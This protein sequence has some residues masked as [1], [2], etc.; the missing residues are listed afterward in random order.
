[1]DVDGTVLLTRREIG[2]RD[3]TIRFD[4]SDLK[5][6]LAL[7]F[8]GPES[9]GRATL[10]M[11]LTAEQLDIA[12]VPRFVE[13][14]MPLDIDTRFEAKR[15]H[16][17]DLGAGRILAR[18]RQNATVLSVD[19]LTVSDLG[20]ATLAAT[21]AI[22]PQGGT[23]EARLEAS[24]LDALAELMARVLPGGLTSWLAKRTPLYAPASLRIV[25]DSHGM[26]RSELR[27][28]Q[29]A[30]TLG[31]SRVFGDARFTEDWRLIAGGGLNL[32]LEA[33]QSTQLL[34]QV[35]IDV[36]QGVEINRPGRV[37]VALGGPTGA[38]NADL[39]VDAD[40]GVARLALKGSQLATAGQ[41]FRGRLTVQAEDAVP[42]GLSLGIGPSFLPAALPFRLQS[43][44]LLAN[45]KLTLGRLDAAIAGNP[46]TGEIAFNFLEFG[47]ISGQLKTGAID[48]GL[49]LPIIFGMPDGPV[50]PGSWPDQPF[51]AAVAP[52]LPGDVWIEAERLMHGPETIATRPRMVFRFERGLIFLDHVAA[53]MA[54]G[55]VVG[56]LTLRRN[57][58]QV[59]L[60]GDLALDR[61]TL[62]QLP[63]LARIAGRATGTVDFSAFG[64][65]Y[66]GL[67]ASVAGAARV[68]V[69]DL[70]VPGLDRE[71]LVR[72]LRRPLP[73]TG[74]FDQA[75]LARDFEAEVA[76]G[77]LTLPAADIALSA[78]TGALRIA[79]LGIGTRA[80]PVTLS[81]QADLKR[82][83]AGARALFTVVDTPAGWQG[84][85]LPE[86]SA[87]WS[88][89][90]GGEGRSVDVASLAS[91]LTTMMIARDLER[92][93][94]FEQDGRERQF[95][96]RR[97]RASDQQR[98][99]EEEEAA[100]LIEEQRQAE[101][102]RRAE[103]E[104]KRLE[105]Q[106]R[107]AEQRRIEE[108]K[109]LDDQRRREL[110][111]ALAPSVAPAVGA[112][113]DL[114]P[115]AAQN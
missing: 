63:F 102:A 59:S 58:Q 83:T 39:S 15:V 113:I 115:P 103:E 108:Q 93:E 20:G 6:R 85:A 9:N 40:I 69:R 73:D 23:F 91:G 26:E 29:F 80:A 45:A 57:A 71:A 11:D 41:P 24:R 89:G 105:E 95:F 16:F 106:R 77:R 114:R 36:P 65:S 96:Q 112:P 55:N 62:Q 30:G 43:D 92:I 78:A 84:R 48:A 17:A 4:R 38:T 110:A 98:L 18:L 82:W 79:P 50:Q 21:G 90:V 75:A 28:F 1:M 74:T 101:A 44:V 13:I 76:K 5:G 88:T 86:A 72:L 19:E 10:A 64:T 37:S 25:I 49:F 104:R 107:V 81:A 99:R 61:L 53:E 22:G 51:A 47:R 68:D 54:G 14:E 87:L 60:T 7:R 34:R 109:R 94:A 8:P 33:P 67:M 70:V 32:T 46:L 56:Q 12:S 2:V 35:G 42:L 31:Q 111:P 66:A 3:A 52:P 97:Q 100:R 27:R